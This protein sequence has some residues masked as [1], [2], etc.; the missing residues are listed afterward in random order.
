[1]DEGW[2]SMLGG[3]WGRKSKREI[4]SDWC[5]YEKW[6]GCMGIFKMMVIGYILECGRYSI[7]KN[8]QKMHALDG[9]NGKKT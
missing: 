2:E 4:G 7:G 9:V 6:D 1:M 3:C 8:G 5:R